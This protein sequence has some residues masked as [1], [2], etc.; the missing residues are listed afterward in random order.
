MKDKLGMFVNDEDQDE[1]ASQV[2]DMENSLVHN[3]DNSSRW[4]LEGEESNV[5]VLYAP[6]HCF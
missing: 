4:E 1:G 2:L 6:C 5:S 3:K